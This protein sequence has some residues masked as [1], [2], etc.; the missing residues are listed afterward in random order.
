MFIFILCPLYFPSN[1]KLQH[2]KLHSFSPNKLILIFFV[3]YY[4]VIFG[5]V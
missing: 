3:D 4:F 1:E 5:N 2:I